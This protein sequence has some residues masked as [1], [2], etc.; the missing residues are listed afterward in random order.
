MSS[1]LLVDDNP[2]VRN[3]VGDV[4]RDAGHDVSEV[5]DGSRALALLTDR[6]FDLVILDYL[7]PDVKGDAVAR[8]ARQRCA[9]VRI[10][11]L[12][13]YAEFLSLTGK[14][15][16]EVIIPK[17]I[18]LDDLCAAVENVLRPLAQAA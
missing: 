11:F 15:G 8:F 7:L 18:S 4:L 13:A 16:D 3:I 1:I 14:S 9:T 6:Q 12:T 2:A 5:A 10:A 17:P